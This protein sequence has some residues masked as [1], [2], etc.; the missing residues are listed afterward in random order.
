MTDITFTFKLSPRFSVQLTDAIDS[1]DDRDRIAEL[2]RKAIE[3]V[4]MLSEEIAP[5]AEKAVLEASSHV[6][7]IAKSRFHTKERQTTDEARK[8]DYT[9]KLT[10]QITLQRRRPRR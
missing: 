5:E 3:S 2:A 4:R 1:A 6:R 7:A 9:E 8:K 10:E